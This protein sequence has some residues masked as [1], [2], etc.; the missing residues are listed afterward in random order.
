[1]NQKEREKKNTGKDIFMERVE[2]LVPKNKFD[3]SGIEKL[4][5][6]SDEEIAPILPELLEWMK[7]MNWPIA[8]EMPE[9][10][11]KHQKMITPCIIEALQPEQLECDWKNFIIWDLLPMLDKQYL[12]MIKPCLERIV[13]KPTQGEIFEKTDIEAAEFLK[14][15]LVYR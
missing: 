10:L 13:K 2:D 8:K 15:R 5:M 3:F 11:S 4:R 9:L 14:K 6:L 7:D 1:M 12:V